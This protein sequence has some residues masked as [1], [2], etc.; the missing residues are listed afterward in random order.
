MI[1]LIFLLIILFCSWE[2]KTFWRNLSA[3][4]HGITCHETA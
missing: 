4:R 1:R 2:E 3:K